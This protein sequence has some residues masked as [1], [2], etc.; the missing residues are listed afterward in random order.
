[1]WIQTSTKRF[2]LQKL[3]W[4]LRCVAVCPLTLS[5]R[6]QNRERVEKHCSIFFSFYIW[7][8]VSLSQKILI[9]SRELTI[10]PPTKRKMKCDS[11]KPVWASRQRYIK[12]VAVCYYEYKWSLYLKSKTSFWHFTAMN[13]TVQA[14]TGIWLTDNI[15]RHHLKRQGDD[16][17]PIWEPHVNNLRVVGKDQVEDR[18]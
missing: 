16:L 17:H 10:Q 11:I 8:Q 3:W 1:M 12:C 9:Q 5:E 18:Y 13:P 4:C 2:P 7:L 15:M 14:S 6:N